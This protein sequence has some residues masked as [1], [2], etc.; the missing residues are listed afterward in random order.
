[1]HIEHIHEHAD[2]ERFAARVRIVGLFDN[3]NSAIRRRQ[4]RV[5]L[6]WN[7]ARGIA[8]ELQYEYCDNPERD[9]PGGRK[10]TDRRSEY[11][12]DA[13]KMPAL[14]G[15]DRVRIVIQQYS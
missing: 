2:L 10:K 11:N 12:C 14:A 8:E 7:G 13:Q 5:R 4:N 9:R 1:M 15:D 3:H 6:L